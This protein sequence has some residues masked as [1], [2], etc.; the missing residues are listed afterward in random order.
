[1]AAAVI[2]MMNQLSTRTSKIADAQKRI[3]IIA[4]EAGEEDFDLKEFDPDGEAEED[5]ETEDAET[6]E[7]ESDEVRLL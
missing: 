5:A 4:R 6:A 3:E 7:E 2:I 1:M